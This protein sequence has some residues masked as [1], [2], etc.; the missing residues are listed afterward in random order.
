MKL[1]ESRQF[2][3]RHDPRFRCSCIE[4][5]VAE[6]ACK[7]GGVIPPH[8]NR[9]EVHPHRYRRAY[10][11][12]KLR[13]ISRAETRSRTGRRSAGSARHH[14][15]EHV[16]SSTGESAFITVG[17]VTCAKSFK[18]ACKICLRWSH[19]LFADDV[20]RGSNVLPEKLPRH[21]DGW[22]QRWDSVRK[23]IVLRK[24]SMHILIRCRRVGSLCPPT[25][26]LSNHGGHGVP[27]LPSWLL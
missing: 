11:L 3:S 24:L 22:R 20:V 27:T 14:A 19:A 7:N 4:A 23:A 17:I 25:A 2:S 12:V 18:L 6:I 13:A 15:A 9:A 5:T 26:P 21:D 1:A 16:W 10:W 8:P